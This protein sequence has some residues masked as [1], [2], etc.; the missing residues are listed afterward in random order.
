MATDLA[1]ERRLRGLTLRRLSATTGVAL[2][3]LTGLE[4]GSGWPGFET[5][6]IVADA[7]GLRVQVAGP[8]LLP[9]TEDQD[10]ATMVAAWLAAGYKVAIP[11]QLLVSLELRERMRVV[12]VSKSAVARAVGLRH[13]TV[14]EMYDIGDFRFSSIRTLAA[15]CAYLG[16][17]LEVVP[18]DA[19]W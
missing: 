2:S 8:S 16:T 3:V 7:L 19:P 5:V 11:L 18:A 1:R 14:T 4:Q 15:L 17:R 12:G 10:Q 13:N 6:A 9:Q